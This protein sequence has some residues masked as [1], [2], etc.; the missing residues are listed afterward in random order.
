MI[1]KK[2]ILLAFIQIAAIY[3]P[4][5]V[6]GNTIPDPHD[7]SFKDVVYLNDGCELVV[8]IKTLGEKIVEFEQYDSEEPFSIDTAFISKIQLKDGRI[9]EYNPKRATT[10]TTSVNVSQS[11]R[12]NTKTKR[13][14]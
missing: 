9:R 5:I 12:R 6:M 7:D 14:R 11:K 1:T 13:K 10:K 3:C 4:S 2:K 8:K